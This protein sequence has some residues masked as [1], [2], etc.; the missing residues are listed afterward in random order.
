MML[1]QRIN[2][3]KSARQKLL[4]VAGMSLLLHGGAMLHVCK[5]SAELLAKEDIE[6]EIID[7]RTIIP[8]DAQTCSDSVMRTGRLVV[9]KKDSGV[10]G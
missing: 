6:I 10:G 2:R 7:L 1:L 4:E 5:Q 9:L 3:T 8:F